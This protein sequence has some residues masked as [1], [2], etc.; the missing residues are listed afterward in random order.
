[1]RH[2]QSQVPSPQPSPQ[3]RGGRR[4]TVVTGS[5]ADFGL[6]TPVMRA[7]AARRG[8]RLQVVVTGTHLSSNTWRDVVDAGFDIAARVPM[9]RRGHIGRHADVGALGRGIIG[10][11]VAFTQL[12]PDVVLV[13]GDRIEALAAACAAHVGGLHLAHI[14]GGD[15]AEGVADEAM[16]HAVSKLA[17]LHFA[18]TA[19]S[20]QRLIRMG[21][22]PEWVWNVGSPA[23]D[24]LHDVTPAAAP[25]SLLRE[26]AGVRVRR[27]TAPQAIIMQ[28]PIGATDAQEERQ[29][30]ATLAAT[31]SLTRIILTPNSDPGSAG[32]RRA[33]VGEQV[34]AHLPRPRFLAML[35]GA[36]LIIGNSSA[37]LIEAA[38]LRIP[39]VNIGPRQ[40]GREKPSNVIDTAYGQAPVRAATRK[41]LAIN[42][43]R[44]GHPYGDGHTGPRIAD[45]LTTVNLK[46]L[47]T[48]KQNSY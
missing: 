3:G 48:R 9:Q 1:M 23:V 33:L 7:I 14:H 19:R 20:R 11:G 36:D 8:L 34:V 45:L 15:R 10:L 41:A 4:I 21:E 27:I 42:R 28:H 2:T 29:M 30:R 40:S 13:L 17:H 39:C 38:A 31:R 44:I 46:S 25:L 12:Q 18:A 22:A 32:I 16:R 5:R 47:P 6:L 26:R 24:G 37:G 43:S 35:A